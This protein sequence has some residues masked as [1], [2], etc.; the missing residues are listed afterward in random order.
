MNTFERNRRASRETHLESSAALASGV[1]P[2][3][4]RRASR[5]VVHRAS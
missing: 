4:A 1:D 2:R 5:R 3:D